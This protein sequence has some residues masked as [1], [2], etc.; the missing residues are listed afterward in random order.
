MSDHYT[1]VCCRIGKR[2]KINVFPDNYNVR[3]LIIVNGK[4]YKSKKEFG[5]YCLPGQVFD[6]V[7]HEMMG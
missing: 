7:F 5:G 4:K 1:L 2:P 3:A 6:E